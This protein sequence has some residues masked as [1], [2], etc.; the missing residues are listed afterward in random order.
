[1]QK[2][3]R[4]LPITEDVIHQYIAVHLHI[5]LS[6]GPFCNTIHSID[7]ISSTWG[8]QALPLGVK[9]SGA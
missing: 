2:P 1:M 6:F 5:N 3:H 4:K 7:M 9:V 8:L